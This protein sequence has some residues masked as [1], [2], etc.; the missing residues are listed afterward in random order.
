M[1]PYEFDGGTADEQTAGLAARLLLQAHRPR[2]APATP[3]AS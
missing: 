3:P 2:A 1:G